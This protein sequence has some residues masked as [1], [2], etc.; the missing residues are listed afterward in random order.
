[1]RSAALCNGHLYHYLDH[2]A[3]LCDLLQIPLLTND[4]KIEKMAHHYYPMVDTRYIAPAEMTPHYLGTN[5]DCFYV[6]E[7]HTRKK[8]QKLIETTCNKQV[9][10]CYLP[11]GN[12]DKGLKNPALNPFLV[13]EL[14]L[15]YGEQMEERFCKNIPCKRIGNFRYDFYLRYKNFYDELVQKELQLP[16]KKIYLYA[17]T[18][19]D[20]ENGTTIFEK[21][22]FPEEAHVIVNAHPLLF[23]THLA[24]MI[25][26][27]PLTDFPLIYPLL[28]RTDAYIGD[29]SS[30]GYDFLTFDRPLYFCGKEETELSK[31]GSPWPEENDPTCAEKRQKLY[32]KVFTLCVVLL[33][34]L[35]QNFYTSIT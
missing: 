21:K 5:F 3:P 27:D 33:P 15:V 17:P 19:N 12:S 29:Y 23:E 6:T 32:K 25:A 20:G 4:L 8:L 11:H 16:N 9:T 35:A 7:K 2:L 30:I 28:A 18:W 14:A 31:C 10:F 13:Q 1:M 24:E 22:D 26:L 34:F